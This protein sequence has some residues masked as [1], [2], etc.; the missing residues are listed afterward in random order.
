[1]SDSTQNLE[2]SS[3]LTLL[4]VSGQFDSDFDKLVYQ[5]VNREAIARQAQEELARRLAA[6]EQAR[7]TAERIRKRKQ[8]TVIVSACAVIIALILFYAHVIKPHND[9]HRAAELMESGDYSSALTIFRSLGEYRD[10]SSQV[11]ACRYALFE[12]DYQK[13]VAYM[14]GAD[15]E[16]ASALFE[17][18]R[19]YKD[20]DALLSE[21]RQAIDENEYADALA[22]MEGGSYD[23]AIAKFSALGGFR[24]SYDQA[25]HCEKLKNVAPIINAAVGDS[26]EY[27]SFEQDNN[28]ENGKEAIE[29]L[30]LEKTDTK[31]L[32]LSKYGLDCQ[33]YNQFTTSVTWETCSLRA[34]LNDS[35]LNEAFGDEELA[36]I[37]TTLVRAEK[38]DGFDT[39]PGADTNDKV[40]LLSCDDAER[41]FSSD[42]SRKCAAS[43]YAQKRSAYVGD[44]GYCWWWLR[45]PGHTSSYATLVADDGVVYENYV[46]GYNIM[47]FVG[48]NWGNATARPAVWVNIE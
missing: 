33:R 48:T 45:S 40:F 24:D 9:Y 43:D 17:R 15:Y 26:V 37:E 2:L 29:W 14:A 34:W 35:F 36:Y 38:V 22:L 46:A 41:Y 39:D 1:M 30:I 8:A 42:Q 21:C 5:Y 10:S 18:T 16:Q 23:A 13:A 31:A 7:Q 19:T 20:S 6:E 3:F 27:G 4:N 44:S 28:S 25:L 32:L 11:E 47:P 12:P